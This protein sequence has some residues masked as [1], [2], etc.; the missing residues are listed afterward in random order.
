M[1]QWI[2]TSYFEQLAKDF[3]AISHTKDGINRFSIL[4]EDSIAEE[5]RG[6]LDFSSWC[7]L[8]EKAPTKVKANESDVLHEYR[9]FR[10]TICRDASRL[11]ATDKLLIFEEAELIAKKIFTRILKDHRKARRTNIT[12]FPLFDLVHQLDLEN[13]EDILNG[14]I[15]GTDAKIT[16]KNPFNENS[17]YT[18][19]EWN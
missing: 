12:S 14:D 18:E 16:I 10:F 13:F 8:L 5:I 3:K 9:T 1:E 19:S 17:Y 4:D 7:L 2:I 6:S 11:G 15:I